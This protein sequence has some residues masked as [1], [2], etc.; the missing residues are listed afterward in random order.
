MPSTM[1]SRF[2]RALTLL[3]I[4]QTFGC[5]DEPAVELAETP[6][7]EEKPAPSEAQPPAKTQEPG[8]TQAP[9]KTQAPTEPQPPIHEKPTNRLAKETSPYLLLHA[10]NP[11]DWYPWGEEAFAKA[12]AEGKVVFL[13][14]GYSSCHWCHVMERESFVD[15][16]IAAY[17]NEHFVCIKVDR[18]ERPDVDSIYMTSVQIYNQVTGSGRGGGWPMSVFMTP[19]A[20][21]F[22][23]GTY[24]PARDG[25]RG[26]GTGFFTLLK[27][28]QQFW[29]EGRE[30]IEQDAEAITNL[31][32]QEMDRPRTDADSTVEPTIFEQSLQT[33][34]DQY[35]P[36]YGGFGYAPTNPNRPKFPEPPNL[37]F[38][39]HRLQ[40]GKL[41]ETE[42]ETATKLLV[43]TLQ[44]MAM[45]GIRDHLGGGFH[46][47][48]V[49]RFWR[50]PHFEKMLY[51]NGQLASV[52]AEAYALTGREDFKR[53][54]DELLAFVSREM[55][56]ERGAFVSA[57]DAESEDEE[58]KFYRWEKPEVE[59]LLAPDEF[60]LFA[61]IYGLD[62]EPNFEEDYY[63]P[64]LSKTP[65]ELAEQTG[66]S[67][68]ELEEALVPLRAKLLAA[69]DQRERPLTDTKILTSWNGLM[70]R[71]Y[72]DAGRLLQNEAYINTAS[73]AAD[74]VLAELR[75][76]D[77]RLQRTYGQGKSALNA[78][79]D[80]Y[81]FLA[82][83][84]IALHRASGDEKWLK[85]AEELTTKQMELFWDEKDG[86]FYFTSGDHETLLA[87]G[88]D[89][90]D[91]VEPSGNSVSA[92][93]LVYLG[94]TLD[95][96]EHLERAK[97]TIDA[98]AALL[99][100]APHAV[101][102]MCVAY[103]ALL[104]ATTP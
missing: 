80:D 27:R 93:N 102:R 45:G 8:K 34:A 89:P 59:K 104:E 17:M 5:S 21:P 4:A 90:I 54:V 67:T 55:T 2:L 63:A 28:V 58:G 20:K 46:R 6:S 39:I 76:D 100:Q 7:A 88:R 98:A 83:G 16:E 42:A 79:L 77:G 31:V 57:L 15:E 97:Q 11:V 62:A 99:Q 33:L 49:D 29:D 40:S 43:G 69:R 53:V 37:D 101:P 70:I 51:D 91:G 81:A 19:E 92:G 18:E 44:R 23:G 103:Q 96:P 14:V 94:K 1:P 3:L 84:L 22:F 66:L 85:T 61:Q 71:G 82:D 36:E 50:I 74:F 95:K 13:S 47:Y 68:A 32:K 48:S 65:A 25:D 24:F 35:D 9:A 41:N 56:D 75:T 12:K 73:R 52:Y 38:L 72:A 60:K 86:G 10:H 78:Y 64:Q 30:A 26:A 87:R